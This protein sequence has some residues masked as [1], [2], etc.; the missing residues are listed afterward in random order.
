M[1][2]RQDDRITSVA[3]IIA[4]GVNV[5]GRREVL[6]MDIGASEAETFWTCFLRN[7]TV[8]RLRGVKL[9]ISD[10]R[11]VIKAALSKVMN[12]TWLRSRVHV[13]RNDPAHAPRSGKRIISAFIGKAF[14]Q[15]DAKSVSQGAAPVRAPTSS[16]ISR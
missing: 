6:G 16:S 8:R 15:E 1:K 9:V 2:L 3:V 10:A 7:L 12:A 13:M 4:V 14:A 11:L 5:D